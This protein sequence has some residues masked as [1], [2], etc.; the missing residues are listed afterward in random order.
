M[1]KN[2]VCFLD[3]HKRTNLIEYYFSSTE[4]IQAGS[5]WAIQ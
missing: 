3:V 1:E 4:N 2:K 5:P